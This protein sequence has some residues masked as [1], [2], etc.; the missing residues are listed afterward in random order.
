MD[1]VIISSLAGICRDQE[2]E[3]DGAVLN[4]EKKS[5]SPLDIV[6]A[7]SDTNS[8]IYKEVPP[9]VLCIADGAAAYI[10]K[11]VFCL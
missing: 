7:D 11:E 4:K 9:G 10:G 8:R 3:I 5:A 6:E 1:S 2:I